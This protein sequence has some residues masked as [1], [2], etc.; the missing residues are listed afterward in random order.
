ME[1]LPI[2][3]PELFRVH[4]VHLYQFQRRTV[5][6]LPGGYNP[7]SVAG[8]GQFQSPG[9]PPRPDG[10]S[11]FVQGVRRYIS[12]K[13]FRWSLHKEPQPN[14]L[15]LFVQP[16]SSAVQIIL[17][18]AT[19]ESW[20]SFPLFCGLNGGLFSQYHRFQRKARLGV[21]DN[22]GMTVAPTQSMRIG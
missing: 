21:D 7:S 13:R 9:M 19:P 20:G 6:Q 8:P 11:G 12:Q 3:F 17:I 15:P 16:L 2:L 22:G 1:S 14:A 4:S 10:R 5:G 18:P